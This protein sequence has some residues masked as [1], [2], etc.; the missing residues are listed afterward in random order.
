MLFSGYSE[1]RRGFP[2]VPIYACCAGGDSSESSANSG[3][4]A[5]DSGCSSFLSFE[6][7]TMRGEIFGNDIGEVDSQSAFECANACVSKSDCHSAAYVQKK[8]TCFL[9]STFVDESKVE[10]DPNAV[11]LD[12]QPC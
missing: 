1:C 3:S 2:R 8:L 10:D 7:K 12:T 4:D 11:L 9:K 5:S 6:G